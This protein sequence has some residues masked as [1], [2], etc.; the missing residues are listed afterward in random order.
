[1][2]PAAPARLAG[3]HRRPNRGNASLDGGP[4]GRFPTVRRVSGY[5]TENLSEKRR[6]QRQMVLLP[7]SVHSPYDC[8]RVYALARRVA[9][10]RF[11]HLAESALRRRLR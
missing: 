9:E 1:M 7:A 6:V 11:R 3:G 2:E 8:D 4:V 5:S 10:P